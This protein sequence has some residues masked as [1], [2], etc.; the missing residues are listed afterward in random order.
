M[1]HCGDRVVLKLVRSSDNVESELSGKV[2]DIFG[3][4][5]LA[6]LYEAGKPPVRRSFKKSQLRASGERAW[7]VTI[8]KQPEPGAAS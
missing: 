2:I 7:K 4:T 1:I 3:D 8:V 6:Q 5:V